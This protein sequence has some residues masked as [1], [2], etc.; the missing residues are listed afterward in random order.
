MKTAKEQAFDS[1]SHLP[2]DATWEDLFYSLY[3]R[4]KIE[5]G[6]KAANNG[7]VLSHD[8]VKRLFVR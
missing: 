3:V 6:V 1:I 7:R 5:E 4:R 8:E 2:S